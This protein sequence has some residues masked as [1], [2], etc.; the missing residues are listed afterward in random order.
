MSPK[1]TFTFFLSQYW[2]HLGEHCCTKPRWPVRWSTTRTPAFFW[3]RWSRAI[4]NGH[5]SWHWC[6]LV[7]AIKQSIRLEWY[8]CVRL[9]MGFL[10]TIKKTVWFIFSFPPET[11][12][13]D[14]TTK[15]GLAALYK[16]RVFKATRYERPLKKWK[17]VLTLRA[18]TG[19]VVTLKDGWT[20]L[21]Y[22]V[23]ITMFSWS[24]PIIDRFHHPN[25][26]CGGNYYWGLNGRFCIAPL[27]TYAHLPYILRAKSSPQ[28]TTTP[29]SD[30]FS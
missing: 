6:K 23:I 18:H 3:R 22:K 5:F 15:S 12:P 19:V 27:N 1:W 9:G 7:S 24:L 17:G 8:L 11:F 13:Y 2:S 25:I 16:M 4:I 21:V 30:A 29:G 10:E 28:S 20:F 14:I 26:D